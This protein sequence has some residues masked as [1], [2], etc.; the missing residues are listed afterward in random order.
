MNGKTK[1][2]SDKKKNKVAKTRKYAKLAQNDQFNDFVFLSLHQF[3]SI[4][5]RAVCSSFVRLREH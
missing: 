2:L 1:R 3:Y 5:P 4:L